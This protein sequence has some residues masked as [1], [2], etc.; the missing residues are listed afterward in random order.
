MDAVLM[1]L[2]AV[3]AGAKLVAFILASELAEE[4]DIDIE[5]AKAREEGRADEAETDSAKKA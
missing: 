3:L 5:L 4:R 1:A 2:A